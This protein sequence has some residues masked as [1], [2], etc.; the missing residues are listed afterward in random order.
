MR[1]LLGLLV[2]AAS[3]EAQQPTIEVRKVGILIDRDGKGFTRAPF[4]IV[5]IANGQFALSETNVAPLIVNSSGG[6]VRRF[7]RGDGPGEFQVPGTQF[8]MAGDTLYATNGSS[9]NIY[10]Q[11]GK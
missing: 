4:S 7:V 5:P 3:L 9:V 11:T 8:R 1:R 6:L 2:L 10:D